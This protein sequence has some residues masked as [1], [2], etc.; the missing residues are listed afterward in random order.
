MGTLLQL[1]Q[2]GAR[3]T[4]MQ[5]SHVHGLGGAAQWFQQENMG[6]VYD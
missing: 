1:G 5:P 4:G 2:K 3:A 6:K